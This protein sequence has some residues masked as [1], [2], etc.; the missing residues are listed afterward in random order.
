MIPNSTIGSMKIQFK[1]QERTENDAPYTLAGDENGWYTPAELSPGIHTLTV[2]P[3]SGPNL[4]GSAGPSTT[5]TFTIV[6]S[7]ALG[8]NRDVLLRWLGMK[9][10][11]PLYS[12][13]H[14]AIGL[15]CGP[16]FAFL[17][18]KI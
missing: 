18:L 9:S 7:S 8:L 2:T 1:G 12:E 13:K 16:R 17:G 6:D 5:I 3:Y 14:L 4:G 11:N 15:D 10:E